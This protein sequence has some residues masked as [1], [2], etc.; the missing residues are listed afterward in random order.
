MSRISTE[1]AGKHA[2]VQVAPVE[3]AEPATEPRSTE[4]EEV[5]GGEAPAGGSETGCLAF[6][7]SAAFARSCELPHHTTFGR[8]ARRRSDEASPKPCAPPRWPSDA[9]LGA[10]PSALEPRVTSPFSAAGRAGRF[11]PTP[12]SLELSVARLHR[13]TDYRIATPPRPRETVRLH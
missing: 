7:S 10:R 4:G 5:S 1:A 8:I 6:R 2:T 12:G 3:K 9:P 13:K 11:F